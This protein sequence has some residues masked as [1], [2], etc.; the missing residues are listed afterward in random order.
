MKIA[1]VTAY[2]VDQPFRDGPYSCAG[3]T[4][5]GFDSTVIELI[6]DSGH[7]G[8]GEMAP[9]GAFY[10][11]AFA[12]GA[13]A[14]LD[15][16]GPV[17]IGQ[18]PRDHRRLNRLMDSALKGHPYIKSALDMACWDLASQAAEVPLVAL[19]GGLE[20]ETVELYR[21]I[22]PA[23]P[24]D[25]VRL[26]EQYLAE[27]YRRLQVKVGGDP[28]GDAECLRAVSAAVPAE[29]ILFCD[30]N[31]GWSCF[32][33]RR[34]LE[35]TR[36]LSY[37]LEQPCASYAECLS[38]RASCA[39][40]LVLDESV[41]SLEALLRLHRDGAADG[42]TLKIARLGGVTKTRQLRDLAVDLGLM[43]TV[44]DTGGAEID[45]A[46]MAHLSL[47]TPEAR[48]LH[49]VDFH[50]WVTVSLGTGLA[51]IHDGKMAAPKAAGLGID[52]DRSALGA[53]FCKFGP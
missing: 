31:G 29:V 17:L 14:G 26:A 11:E 12:A 41:D 20:G 50:N 53:P 6:C 13:R 47:S 38:V 36:D 44:E 8:W 46:A 34:F 32:E 30:A 16:L 22:S 33:V 48:R 45:T 7:V 10:S 25:M 1:G 2:R 24:D 23:P 49:T 3:G 39:K 9:L 18:D 27:G 40:P 52:V 15:E 37:V 35:V 21:A 51:P 42:V 5:E 28:I 19:L 4:A 43:V